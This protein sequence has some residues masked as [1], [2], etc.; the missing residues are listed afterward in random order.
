MWYQVD[1][2]LA[3]QALTYNFLP[4]WWLSQYGLVFGER[5]VFDPHYRLDTHRFMARTVHG[6]FPHLHIGS[7]DP[8]LRGVM[9]DFG[10]AITAAAAGCEVVYPMDN[11]PWSHH[12]PAGRIPAL[13]VPED[14]GQAYPYCE[15]KAQVEMMRGKLG[16][17]FPAALNTRGVLN[18]ALLIGGDGFFAWLMDENI[19][20]GHLAAYSYAMMC[21]TIDYNYRQWQF[22]DMTIIP[23]C[24]VMMISPGMYQSR[25]LH[26]DQEVER[27]LAGY[28][29]WL[30]IH[31]CG[32]FERYARAY[33]LIP[34]LAWIEI[35]WGSDPRAAL[36]L[37]PEATVQ[38]IL[39]AV[40]VAGSTR[41]QVRSRVEELLDTVRGDWH[42]FRISMPDVEAGTPDENLEEIYWACKEMK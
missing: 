42:R 12:L 32:S 29:A 22:P 31:H 15:I 37:F 2:T 35:G 9:P 17:D 28:G 21:A 24:T 39:S 13:K 36:D 11:Y 4:S 26:F 16:L 19:L 34:R 25:F 1:D 18:D 40:F 10:N 41:S 3:I 7:P 20:A 33:R 8:P 6:R 38:Y 30:G 27:R 23:N 5:M 14:I